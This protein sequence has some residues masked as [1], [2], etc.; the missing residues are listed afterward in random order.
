MLMKQEIW[1][2]ECQKKTQVVLEKIGV[3]VLFERIF[4]ISSD[5]RYAV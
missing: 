4:G 2:S 3:K 1:Y 5:Y